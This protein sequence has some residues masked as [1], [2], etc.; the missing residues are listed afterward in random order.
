MKTKLVAPSEPVLAART[1]V[2]ATLKKHQEKL[3]AEE[4]LAV[5]A[6][7]VGQIIA[8]QDQH[9]ITREAALSLVIAN[10]EAGN[11]EAIA[12]LYNAPPGGHA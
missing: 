12:S 1:D 6:H 3:T 4:I 10:I 7:L 2:L 11:A 9:K 8:F 5:M